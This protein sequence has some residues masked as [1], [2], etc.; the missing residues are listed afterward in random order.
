MKLQKRFLVR[1]LAVSAVYAVL[2]P[3]VFLLT[4]DFTYMYF[5][6]NIVLSAVP[7]LLSVWFAR[8]TPK[9]IWGTI[10]L[11][12]FWLLF[13]PNA[14]YFV[15]DLIYVADHA[16]AIDCGPYCP[17]VYLDGFT[18]WLALVD[19]LLGVILSLAMG[20]LS[21]SLMRRSLK[22]S[23]K[24]WILEGGTVLVSLLCGL[25]VYIGRFLRYNS[26]NLFSLPDLLRDLYEVVSWD[27]LGFVLLLSALQYALL[28]LFAPV[29]DAS[30]M[31][32]RSAELVVRE[33]PAA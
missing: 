23:V 6:W 32:V 2:T 8:K 21:I 14:L 28:F 7:L 31:A 5:G 11:F 26:W 3:F 33:S 19:I 12:G 18:D 10:L 4:N 16:F 20:T 27:M 24:A 15:T 29:I 9:R 22:P 1:L 17:T 25:G 13:L 30:L